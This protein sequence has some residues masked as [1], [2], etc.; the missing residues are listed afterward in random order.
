[1]PLT[2]DEMRGL[3]TKLDDLCREAKELRDRVERAMADSKQQDLPHRNSKPQ[4]ASNDPRPQPAKER[5]RRRP[6]DDKPA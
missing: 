6:R 3:M 5:R 4:A 1:M 2:A